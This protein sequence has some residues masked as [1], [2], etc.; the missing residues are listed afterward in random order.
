MDFDGDGQID[1]GEIIAIKPDGWSWGAAED[2]SFSS[3]GKYSLIDLPGE[4]VEDWDRLTQRPVNPVTGDVDI[5]SKPKFK[6]DLD[7]IPR[8]AKNAI[9]NKS[10]VTLDSTLLNT[11]LVKRVNG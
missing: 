6:L 7:A 3:H 8:T 9:K 1:R 2:P 5:R 11:N 4:K 10:P